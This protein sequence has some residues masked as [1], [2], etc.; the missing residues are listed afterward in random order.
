MGVRA[1]EAPV[2]PAVRMPAPTWKGPMSLENHPMVDALV[3]GPADRP[4]GPHEYRRSRPGL[5]PAA[6]RSPRDRGRRAAPS[7]LGAGWAPGMSVPS[8]VSPVCGSA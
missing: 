7:S 4:D 5:R 2:R 6:S 8:A 1:G 3:P